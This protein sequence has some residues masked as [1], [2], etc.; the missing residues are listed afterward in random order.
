MHIS[1]LISVYDFTWYVWNIALKKIKNHPR[2]YRYK[3]I[4]ILLQF[5]ILRIIT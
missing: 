5:A 1:E 4:C 3:K 2:F